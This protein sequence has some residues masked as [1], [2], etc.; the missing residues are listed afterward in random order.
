MNTEFSL[1]LVWNAILK[2]IVWIILITVVFTG[3]AGV[4]TIYQKPVYSSTATFYSINVAGDL[5][6][7]SSALVSAQQ[8]FVNDFIVI[9]KSEKMLGRVAD[10]I[11]TQFKD[12]KYKNDISLL[13]LMISAKQIENT[14]A[15]TVTVKSNSPEEAK[16][17]VNLIADNMRP[18]IDDAVKRENAV[19]TLSRGSEPEKVSPSLT[20]NVI[21][22]FALGFAGSVIM[23]TLIMLY[24][25][26]IRTEEDIKK[27]FKLPIIGVIPE[28][29]SPAKD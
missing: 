16:Y 1:K 7:S 27:Y 5:S 20:R 19:A 11:E 21:I 8:M 9:T 2:N 28:W 10:D 14:S 22:G 3:A 15:F 17:I 25:R 29:D 24:D 18:V 12:S 6:Y 26:T 13:G 23:F 4:L